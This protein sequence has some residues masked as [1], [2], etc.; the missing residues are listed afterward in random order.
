ML[1]CKCALHVP[2]GRGLPANLMASQLVIAAVQGLD[3]DS[4]FHASV[5]AV[6]LAVHLTSA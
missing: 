6:S 3:S 4:I 2:G 5:D 1:M